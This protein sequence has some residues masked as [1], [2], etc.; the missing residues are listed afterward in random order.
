[1]KLMVMQVVEN[2]PLEHTSLLSSTRLRSRIRVCGSR[3]RVVSGG[4]CIAMM[5]TMGTAMTAAN[6]GLARPRRT[7]ANSDLSRSR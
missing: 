7:R 3:V 2:T 4:S 5:M 1:M 6:T